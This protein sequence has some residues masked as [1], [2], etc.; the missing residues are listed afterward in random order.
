MRYEKAVYVDFDS[1]IRPTKFGWPGALE[2]SHET[3]PGALQWLVS[4]TQDETRRVHLYSG[5][6]EYSND[7]KSA[8]LYYW[9]LSEGFS[10]SLD[11][12]LR[13]HYNQLR[14]TAIGKKEG[15]TAFE[16][17]VPS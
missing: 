10:N 17:D 16:L 2:T 4:L 11:I 1:L 6:N 15:F 13:L 12:Q 5:N 3:K 9:L 8:A 7:E 14:L